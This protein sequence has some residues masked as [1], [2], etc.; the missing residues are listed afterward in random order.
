EAAKELGPDVR[1]VSLPSFELF[2]RQCSKYRESVLPAA[3]TRRVSIEAGRTGLW[4]KYVGL[5]GKVIGNDT[6]GLSAPGAIAF[7][8]TG[9]TKEA[10][11]AAVKSLV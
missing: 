6:F 1:V 4:W 9:I 7:R 11:V 5:N 8:E 2:D 3:V 10:L